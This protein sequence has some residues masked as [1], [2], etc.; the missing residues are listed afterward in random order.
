MN[1]PSL[2]KDAERE[3][4]ENGTTLS[5]QLAPIVFLTAIF[6]L[7]FLARIILSPLI[8]TIEKDM[9]LG[10]G[11][12][13]FFFLFV[14]IGYFVS[15][16]GSGFISSRISHKLTITVSSIAVGLVLLGVC[17]A[18]TVWGI[19][20]CMLV[21]GLAAGVY[22]PSG[23]AT[24]THLVNPRQWGKA[25]AI[26]EL[27]PN[28]GFVMAPLVAEAL[29]IWFSWRG[30]MAAIGFAS[31][32]AGLSFLLFGRGG[33]FT[34]EK[35][36]FDSIRSLL[37][38][39]SF[40]V[41]VVLFS[42]GISSTVGI[43]SMLPLYLVADH[44]IFRIQANT[45]VAIS[46]VST[47][48]IVFLG[49]WAADRFGA[50]RTMSVIFLLTGIMTILLGLVNTSWINLIVILQPVFAVCFFPVGFALLSAIVPPQSRGLAVSLAIPVGFVIGAGLVP[51]G[52][53]VLGDAGQFELGFILLGV[54]ILSGS[55]LLAFVRLRDHA[56]KTL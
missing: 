37:T 24:I 41:M 32:L 50:T 18:E 1:K 45:I 46:R 21:L 39:P 55:I 53:G 31:I 2:R 6:F 34:G 3:Q 8:P 38:K 10:H 56:G 27:A 33:E 26:H 47:I 44:G 48:F 13:G 5:A 54:F 23:I 42:L 14:T 11:E 15:L 36:N 7:N 12:V 17:F 40:W 30:V 35:P 20:T 9:S 51:A 19:G 52:I 29:M 4:V 22:L 28:L 49:G 16:V 43:Y 25:I